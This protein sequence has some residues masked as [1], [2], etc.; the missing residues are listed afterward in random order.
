MD[1]SQQQQRRATFSVE[2]HSIDNGNF[3]GISKEWLWGPICACG[4]WG[5]AQNNNAQSN[6]HH[7]ERHGDKLEG[8]QLP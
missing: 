8:K 2:R 3:V 1:L 5:P 7:A 4:M 6:G